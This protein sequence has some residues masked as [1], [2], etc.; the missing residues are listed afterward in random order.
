VRP[1]GTAQGH[2][3]PRG[4]SPLMGLV[5][6]IAVF[7]AGCAIILAITALVRGWRAAAARELDTADPAD[8]D[9]TVE[10]ISEE[11][12]LEQQGW[13]VRRYGSASKVRAS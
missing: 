2:Q 7:L 4:P 8:P 13:F 5:V 11:E 6:A 12:M 10:A 1:L 3:A 9:G